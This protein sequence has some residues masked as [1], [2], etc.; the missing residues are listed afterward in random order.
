MLN[1][2]NNFAHR[3][4]EGRNTW[5]NFSGGRVD[6]G[7]AGEARLGWVR[8]RKAILVNGGTFIVILLCDLPLFSENGNCVVGLLTVSKISNYGMK[9]ERE[10]ER[11]SRTVRLFW[12]ANLTGM[13]NP[14]CSWAS[15]VDRGTAHTQSFSSP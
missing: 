14:S 6:F 15:D 10:R 8:P 1:M 5:T 3:T 11:E 4:F 7:C 2:R 9:G 13:T 12:F